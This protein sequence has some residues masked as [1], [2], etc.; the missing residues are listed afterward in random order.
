[1]DGVL[2]KSSF[3][4]EILIEMIRQKFQDRNSAIEKQVIYQEILKRFIRKLGENKCE[5]YD[6]DLLIHEYLG[7][8]NIAWTCEI[9]DFFNSTELT[10]YTFLY[11]DVEVLGWL[12]EKGYE[13][14]ILTNGLNKYQ[15]CVIAQLGLSRFFKKCIMPNPP[16][17]NFIKPNPEIFKLATTGSQGTHIMIGDSLYFD[18]Y[19]AK[20]VGYQTVW[21]NRRLP[22]TYKEMPIPIRTEK[23]RQNGKLLL[24]SILQSAPFL[25]LSADE[26]ELTSYKPD[27]VIY[28]LHELKEFL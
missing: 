14:A 12:L 21:L 5:A 9:E 20:Q 4:G 25:K 22:N 7:E 13:M 16:K 8:H 18:I 1:M 26:K 6:W 15:D 11:N 17:I 27:Y 28:N 24:R 2:I 23:V 3:F 10:K 19:G